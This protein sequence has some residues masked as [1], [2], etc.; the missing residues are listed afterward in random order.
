MFNHPVTD[1]RLIPRMSDDDSVAVGR[2][3]EGLEHRPAGDLWAELE[4]LLTDEV[5]CWYREGFT[6][7]PALAR[8][9]GSSGER[10]RH[11]ALDLAA[12]IVRTLHRNSL[13]DEV[14]RANAESVAAL[15]HLARARLTGGGPPGLTRLLQDALAF[16]GYTFW[17][18][19]SL[20]FTDEHYHVGCPHCSVRLAIVIGEYGHY[21]AF[22]HHDDGDIHRIPLKPAL[23]ETLTG[24]GRWMHDTAATGGD[25][26]LADGL[27]YLF[28]RATCGLCGSTFATAD[29]FEAENSPHQPIDPVIVRTHRST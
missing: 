7:L 6:A 2:L 20:D 22:R 19:I 17:A 12:V 24:I 28:G 3:L 18:V 4:R 5:E 23:P 27:T 25:M 26:T 14:V 1:Q 8:I 21:S 13:Y 16:A 9:A 15:H 11:R 29:E 10:D